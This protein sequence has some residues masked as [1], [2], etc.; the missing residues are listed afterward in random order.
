VTSREGERPSDAGKGGGGADPVDGQVWQISPGLQR[1]AANVVPMRRDIVVPCISRLQEEAPMSARLPRHARGSRSRRLAQV[2]PLERRRLLAVAVEGAALTITGTPGDDVYVVNLTATADGYV[3]TVVENGVTT[4]FTAGQLPANLTLVANL[5]DGDDT[6]TQAHDAALPTTVYGEAGNDTLT[7]ANAHEGVNAFGQDG[8]DTL[9]GSAWSDLLSGGAGNDY[10]DA[11]ARNDTLQGDAGDDTLLGGDGADRFWGETDSG[12]DS[13]VGGLGNDSMFAGDGNDTLEGNAGADS[14][15]GG[16]GDDSLVGGTGND[17]LVGEGDDDYLEG[18]SGRDTLEGDAGFTVTPGQDTLIGGDGSD[19]LRG[20]ELGDSLVGGSGVDV[21]IGDVTSGA[22]SGGI[23]TVTG[24]LDIDLFSTSDLA[25]NQATDYDPAIDATTGRTEVNNRIL[26]VHASAAGG[27]ITFTGASPT[28]LR[29]RFGRTT[30]IDT[31]FA[32]ADLDAIRVLGSDGYD[33]VRV[34]LNGDTP[35]LPVSVY[36]GAGND[37]LFF[38]GVGRL[39][40][41]AGDGRDTVTAYQ[42][43]GHCWIYGEDGH[44]TISGSSKSDYLVGGDG[45]DVM[46]GYHGNDTLL[47]GPGGDRLGET[48]FGSGNDYFDGGIGDDVLNA[49]RDSDTVIGGE[50]ADLFS[51]LNDTL[52]GEIVD[53]VAGTDSMG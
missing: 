10:I 53:F 16:S 24:G 23:D 15:R 36:A 13:L 44:D 49:G 19:F 35:N 33:D 9:V 7:F 26:T 8:A 25:D 3:G 38:R 6:Y 27:H 47:G 31:T 45:N 21:L 51:Q 28:E 5:G 29:V 4:T 46:I 17:S 30:D 18:G 37:H 42:R 39:R 32:Y 22:S 12:N 11:G 48:D 43:R 34:D 40:V 50:G 41:Y 14:L 52:P 1:L 20:G 2:D